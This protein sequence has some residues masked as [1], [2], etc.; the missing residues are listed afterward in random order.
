MISLVMAAPYEERPPF[1]K[2]GLVFGQF[3]GK[4]TIGIRILQRDPKGPCL[5]I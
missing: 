3:R 1:C 4:F 2:L 5:D